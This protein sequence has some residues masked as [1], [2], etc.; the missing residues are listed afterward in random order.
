[1][2]QVSGGCGAGGLQQGQLIGR[3]EGGDPLATC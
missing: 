3:T 2:A 1:M